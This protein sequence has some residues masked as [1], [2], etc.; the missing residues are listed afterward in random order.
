MFDKY[1]IDKFFETNAMKVYLMRSLKHEDIL[2]RQKVLDD[3]LNLF[4]H[5]VMKYSDMSRMDLDDLERISKQ[6]GLSRNSQTYQKNTIDF[7]DMSKVAK[8]Q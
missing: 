3:T 4:G 7:I 5:K 8:E 2:Y 6:L 1:G